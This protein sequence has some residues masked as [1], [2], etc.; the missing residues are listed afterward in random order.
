MTRHLMRRQIERRLEPWSTLDRKTPAIGWLRTVREAL[1]MSAA[2]LAARIGMSRQG[3]SDLEARER[4]GTVTLA[5]LRKAANGMECDLVYGIV[6]RT[7][8]TRTLEDQA[9]LTAIREL[10]RVA[11]TM[12]LEA[13]ATEGDALQALVR[14][15]SKELLETERQIWG[16]PR[17]RGPKQ[18][19]RR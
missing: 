15:R 11:H 8:L 4:E 6:P 5:A 14:E 13:Q 10:D 3:V 12:R 18:P 9:R 19:P 7:S 1:G 16:T 2:Q 17:R